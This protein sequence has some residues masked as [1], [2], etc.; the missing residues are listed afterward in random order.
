MADIEVNEGSMVY[1]AERLASATAPDEG[2]TVIVDPQSGRYYGLDSYGVRVWA[3]LQ[4]PRR[5]S[6]LLAALMTEYDVE[7]HV[8]LEDLTALIRELAAAGLV[9]VSDEP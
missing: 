5:V 7:R 8:V 9:R 6:E 3:M 1:A 4:R 2:E